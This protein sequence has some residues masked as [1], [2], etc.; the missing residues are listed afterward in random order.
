V[1]LEAECRVRLGRKTGRGRALLE[2]TELIV[3]GD[4]PLKIPLSAVTA[5]DVRGDTLRVTWPRGTAVLELGTAAGKWALRIRTPRTLM[6]KLGVKPGSRVSVIAVEDMAI[7]RDVGERTPN[8]TVGKAAKGSDIVL[9]FMQ[10][11]KDLA[12]LP[13][14]RAA[15]RENGSI[16]VLWSK[17]RKEF[18]EDDIRAAALTAGLV[19]VKVASV[20]EVLSGLKLVIP[21]AQ[22][23]AK[24]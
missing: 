8:V 23:A 16:W 19:D 17:G 7:L 24:T 12:R 15:I 4:V 5:A 14:L 18:R 9:A 21:V 1:G 2:S 3:R 6:D 11:K 13:R 22:R 10:D 20:S